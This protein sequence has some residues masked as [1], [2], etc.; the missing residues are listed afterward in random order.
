MAIIKNPRTRKAAK[1][2]TSNIE[3][4][5]MQHLSFTF[6]V[7]QPRKARVIATMPEMRIAMATYELKKM[8]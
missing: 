8:S 7:Q 2:M 5:E 6:E 3:K 4:H 1:K